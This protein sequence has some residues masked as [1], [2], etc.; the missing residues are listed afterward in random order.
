MARFWACVILIPLFTLLAVSCQEGGSKG[1]AFS[2]GSFTDRNIHQ[3]AG[4]SPGSIPDYPFPKRNSGK[5]WNIALITSGSHPAYPRLFESMI[6]AL[7]E[8]NW[9][10]P[11]ATLGNS[12]QELRDLR[13]QASAR[14]QYVQF[15]DELSLDL[16]WKPENGQSKAFRDL[17]TGSTG[18]DLAIIQGPLA[19][20]AAVQL[21]LAKVSTIPIL[22]QAVP[23]PR[24]IGLASFEYS[25]FR[26]ITATTDPGATDRQIRMFHKASPFRR[27]GLLYEDNTL[28][29]TGT[30]LQAIQM[31][32]RELGFVLVPYTR[33][34]AYTD[35]PAIQKEANQAYLEGIRQL[36]QNCDAIYLAS[37]AGLNKT[38]IKDVVTITKDAR[39][40]TFA[41]EGLS[42]VQEGIMMGESAVL[43]FSA[44]LF[45]A[46]KVIRMLA[47]VEPMSLEQISLHIPHISINIDTAQA[48]GLNLPLEL[49]LAA[50]LVVGSTQP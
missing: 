21:T 50:D 26:Q 10:F 48:I 38:T 37:Q 32:G 11:L 29:R 5:P 49:I 20:E 3:V 8:L 1:N 4:T 6:S 9:I 39:I 2:A 30:D 28:S 16:A 18:A 19:A 13:R 40:P 15:P 43:L 44:G 47:S 33:V 7:V 36:S 24:A 27:L 41:A 17:L 45:D 46:K 12:P 14:S 34:M 25:G 35:N 23:D 22:I 42:L 31:L